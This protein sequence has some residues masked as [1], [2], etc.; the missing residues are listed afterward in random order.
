MVYVLTVWVLAFFGGDLKN[1]HVYWTEKSLADCAK[2]EEKV[3]TGLQRQR[4]IILA[5]HYCEAMTQDD[6]DKLK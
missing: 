3:D 4:D 1:S 2:L 6:Y 5:E